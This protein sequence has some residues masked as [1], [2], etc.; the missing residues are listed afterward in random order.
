MASTG[1]HKCGLPKVGRPF[2]PKL[3]AL[4]MAL[5]TDFRFHG[6]AN[7]FPHWLL[8]GAVGACSL[9]ALHRSF[10][11]LLLSR[12]AA[13]QFAICAFAFCS[14]L[15]LRR[16]PFLF[17][18][19][20]SPAFLAWLKTCVPPGEK[21]DAWFGEV[22]QVLVAG[23]VPARQFLLSMWSSTGSHKCDLP[24]VGK[25]LAPS[26]QSIFHGVANGLSQPWRCQR[27]FRIGYCWGP[28]R[29]IHLAC[30]L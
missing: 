25:P 24:S 16:C 19:M 3:S 8:L 11:V 23:E 7:G 12:H 28:A 15:P 30:S 6:V 27:F 10:I 17:C 9:Y 1:A 22:L 18:A 26:T 14:A 13:Q 5:Q 21:D 20:A 2:A 4:A 29:C